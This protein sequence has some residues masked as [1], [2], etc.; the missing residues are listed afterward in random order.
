MYPFPVPVLYFIWLHQALSHLA[1]REAF[2]V[3]T[4]AAAFGLA[5]GLGSPVWDGTLGPCIARQFSTT[6]LP[7]AFPC[8]SSGT[9]FG[10]LC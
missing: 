7:G 10:T 5:W 3:A 1:A 4:R 8:S 6:G 2:V 9:L